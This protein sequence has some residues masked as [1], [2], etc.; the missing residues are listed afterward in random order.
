MNKVTSIFLDQPPNFKTSVIAAA[1][2][3]ECKG[4]ILLLRRNPHKSLGDTWGVPAGKLEEGETPRKAAIR[5]VFEEVGLHLRE[6]QLK[7]LP[8]IY[9]R[10]HGADVVLY[11]FRTVFLTLPSYSLNLEEHSCAQWFSIQEA[12]ELPHITGGVKALAYYEMKGRE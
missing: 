3:C 6:E 9:V 11:R 1:C 12:L 2:Y 8:K 4:K 5:E 7:E 10:R